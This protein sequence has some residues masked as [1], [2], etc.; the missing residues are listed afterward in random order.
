LKE[1]VANIRYYLNDNKI[2]AFNGI[3][4]CNTFSDVKYKYLKTSKFNY[5]SLR[6][7]YDDFD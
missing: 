1:Y 6:K 4:T 2:L 3:R 7:K 5:W